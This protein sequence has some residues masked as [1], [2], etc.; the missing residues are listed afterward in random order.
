MGDAGLYSVYDAYANWR[1]EASLSEKQSDS[2]PKS[3]IAWSYLGVL[4]GMTPE[5]S[6]E[7]ADAL[8]RAIE[9][10]GGSADSWCKL[11][12]SFAEIPESLVE[13]EAAFRKA[14][15]FEPENETT[16][17]TFGFF[18]RLPSTEAG[19][20]SGRLAEGGATTTR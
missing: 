12:I 5:R 18:P 1:S 11:G 9:L 4:L 13:A 3:G 20:S 7:A 8:R 10:D 6:G 14:L 15:E 2:E 19:R 17:R 16:W